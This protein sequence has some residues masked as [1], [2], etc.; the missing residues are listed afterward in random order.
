MALEARGRR[1]RGVGAQRGANNK[2][3]GPVLP[4]ERATRSGR[5]RASTV[6]LHC[7]GNEEA[8]LEEEKDGRE[9]FVVK[10]PYSLP[11]RSEFEARRPCA[12]AV[13][14]VGKGDEGKPRKSK[15]S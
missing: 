12:V 1:G 2:G 7:A 15:I 3:S 8:L 11:S 14:C 10:A 5:A 13:P 4:S 9:Q 6:S